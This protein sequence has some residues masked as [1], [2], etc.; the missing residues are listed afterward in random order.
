VSAKK[1]YWDVR[2][3]K[4]MMPWVKPGIVIVKKK[5][6]EVFLKKR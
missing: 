1:R 5:G 4:G 3:K 6:E 2:G